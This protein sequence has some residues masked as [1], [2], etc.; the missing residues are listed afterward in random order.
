MENT[1]SNNTNV[2]KILEFKIGNNI[3]IF[4]NICKFFSKISPECSIIFKSNIQDNDS[5]I[6]ISLM[7]SN[8]Q[9]YLKFAINISDLE[10]YKCDNKI[11]IQT[12]LQ[13]I[14]QTLETVNDKSTTFFIERNDPYYLHIMIDNVISKINVINN[15][16][17]AITIPPMAFEKMITIDINKYKEICA[18]INNLDNM[19]IV[20]IVCSDNVNIIGAVNN[21]KQIIASFEN[22]IEN[23]LVLNKSNTSFMIKCKSNDL[24]LLGKCQEI[25]ENIELYFGTSL[26]LVAK[27]PTKIGNIFIFISTI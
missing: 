24:I 3:Q 27:I 12:N 8:K 22:Y 11:M 20:E 6:I 1:D 15:E 4:Y 7:S 19:D 21:T 10:Y 16:N 2:E 17:D 5:C 13:S 18:E 14:C 23:T 26:P 25:C 9:I